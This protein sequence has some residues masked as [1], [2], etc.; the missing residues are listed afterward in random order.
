MS[1]RDELL[2][3]IEETRRLQRRLVV[4][5]GALAVVPF[6]LMIWSVGLGAF[7]LVMLALVAVCSFWVTAAHNAAH[8]Q[9]LEE[10]D[11]VDRNQGKPLQ[12]AHR[13]WHH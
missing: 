1:R 8:R 13:R 5:F 12:T 11:R 7:T 3:Y 9:K 2:G 6:G 10:L 4:I